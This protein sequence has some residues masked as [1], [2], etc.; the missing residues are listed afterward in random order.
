MD[1]AEKQKLTRWLTIALLTI[2]LL[3]VTS[4]LIFVLSARAFARGDQIAPGVA[5][6]GVDVSRLSTPEAIELLQTQWVPT[7]PEQIKLNYAKAPP[8]DDDDGRPD[9]PDN[10]S[11]EAKSKQRAGDDATD[12]ATDEA[13]EPSE[14]ADDEDTVSISPQQLGAELQLER[15]AQQAYSIGRQGNVWQ[16]TIA[17]LR[18]RRNG[19]DVPVTRE[20]DHAVLHSALLDLE[21]TINRKP[22]DALVEVEGDDVRIIPGE[23]GRTL[24]IDAS[25]TLLAEGLR[26]PRITSLDLVVETE[27]PSI[28][29]EML[30]H[31]NTVLA[32]YSTP[33]NPGKVE[34]THN[35]RLAMGIVNKTVVK[36]GQTISLDKTI[37]SRATEHG[38]KPAPIFLEG[39]VVPSIA[40]G[41][42]QVATT[43]YNVALLANLKID[44]RHHHSR[45][46][47]YAPSGRDATLYGGQLDL[48]FTNTLKH[49]ILLLGYTESAR[50]HAKIIG[51]KEDDYDVELIRSG[52]S[53]IAFSEK[54]QPDPELEE[55]KQ[56]VE[57]KGRNGVRV[58]LTRVVKKGGKEIARQVLHT[59]TYPP[60]TKV[61]RVG[62]KPPEEPEQPEEATT[63][64]KPTP[65]P[66]APSMVDPD[67][68]PPGL[69]KPPTASSD[70]RGD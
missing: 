34:R 20:V 39:E 5:I 21:S 67:G 65:S 69:G 14:A 50:L 30:A 57:K 37:G 70:E 64:T 52:V 16:Q 31:L 43:I 9:T 26:D 11:A 62:T 47:D 68:P 51:S 12:E 35:L 7:L 22:K 42:C 40:G 49:P 56:E 29:K 17:L 8:Q 36:P 19:L 44:E 10:P 63:D 61:I 53:T 27:E 38:Y 1:A 33:F 23:I 48:K 2:S 15:A 41:V 32:A 46:V 18:L 6:A 4:G 55:G 60:Q 54:E 24:D 66:S 58:T 28:T 3:I 25:H 45:P 13:A 59:D